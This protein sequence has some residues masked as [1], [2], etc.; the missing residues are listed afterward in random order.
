MHAAEP[1]PAY[2]T[3]VQRFPNA[4]ED[5]KRRLREV[6]LRISN[7][8]REI[9]QARQELQEAENDC[10]TLYRQLFSTLCPCLRFGIN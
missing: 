4:T 6:A 2:S 1:T 3:Y 10:K 8:E 9:M 5:Q 7:V